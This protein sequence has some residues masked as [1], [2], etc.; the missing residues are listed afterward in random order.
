MKYPI[1][2]IKITKIHRMAYDQA[3]ALLEERFLRT[4]KTDDPKS[5]IEQQRLQIRI[6][7]DELKKAK[8]KIQTL[9]Q[10]L[11]KDETQTNILWTSRERQ[12]HP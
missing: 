2:Q 8:L 10:K 12:T 11:N 6:L 7:S 5:V 3:Y 4:L 9:T 1:S